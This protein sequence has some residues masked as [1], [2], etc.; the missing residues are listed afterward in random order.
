MAVVAEGLEEAAG[1]GEV[2]GDSVEAGVASGEAAASL[3]NE[4]AVEDG[5]SEDAA[6]EVRT[7]Y[8]LK[9]TRKNK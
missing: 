6:E 3:K 9:I 8:C 2:E 4:A 1:E 5:A 7:H